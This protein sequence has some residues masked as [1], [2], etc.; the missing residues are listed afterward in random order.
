M[1]WRAWYAAQFSDLLD[2]DRC[3]VAP[4]VANE[5]QPFLILICLGWG[6]S[7]WLP[8]GIVVLRLAAIGL[9]CL[10]WAD[11]ATQRTFATRLSWH[12]VRKFWSEAGALIDFAHIMATG[13]LKAVLALLGSV[14]VLFASVRYL[15]HQ[16][17]RPSGG[18]A[19]VSACML[20]ISVRHTPLLCARLIV[21]LCADTHSAHALPPRLADPACRGSS[22]CPKPHLPPAKPSLEG[23]ASH[24]GCGGVPLQLSKPRLWR[25]S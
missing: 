7:K 13:P 3:L 22:F 2:C 5:A 11:I 18:V 4:T 8:R 6:I 24:L 1:G 10:S 25:C 17:T 21:H 14:A 23:S 15:T 19:G 12:E 9:L 16:G 20:A